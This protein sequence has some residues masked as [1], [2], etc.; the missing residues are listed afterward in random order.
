MAAR[1]L[2]LFALLPVFVLNLWTSGTD[3]AAQEIKYHTHR[4]IRH[5][6]AWFRPADPRLMWFDLLAHDT[7]AIVSKLDSAFVTR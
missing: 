1:G 3:E 4:F 7:P 2:M 6:Y 5:Q